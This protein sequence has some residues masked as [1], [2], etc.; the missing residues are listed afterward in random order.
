MQPEP[1][2][3]LAKMGDVPLTQ[4]LAGDT[5]GES[6]VIAILDRR[7]NNVDYANNHRGAVAPSG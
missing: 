2:E 3:N 1:S 6:G 7:L 4:I 5:C